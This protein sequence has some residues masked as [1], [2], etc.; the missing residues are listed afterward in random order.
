MPSLNYGEKDKN[1]YLHFARKF[2]IEYLA[3]IS[4]LKE[5]QSAFEYSKELLPFY[6][7]K[8]G[9]KVTAKKTFRGKYQRLKYNE[10]CKCIHTR[11]DT[12]SSQ[13]TIHP[14][15]NRVL[16]IRELMIL[17]TIPD[18]FH[19]TNYDDSITAENSDQY[20]KDNELNI[21]RCIGEAVPT[22]II[23]DISNKIKTY[24]NSIN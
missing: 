7:D 2:P 19:W 22:H 5:G 6:T 1:D 8:N 13:N 12:I 20:L 18:S 10:A 15:D 17:M 11:N 14:T 23:Q 21:R 24:L 16:S 9:N 4:N 3:A